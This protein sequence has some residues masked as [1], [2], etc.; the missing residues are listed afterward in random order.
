M[1]T[2]TGHLQVIISALTPAQLAL[3]FTQI[4]PMSV[5]LHRWLGQGMPFVDRELS[6]LCYRNFLF[7]A[8]TAPLFPTKSH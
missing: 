3:M 6:L 8:G 7:A 4:D 1:L 5:C 2:S